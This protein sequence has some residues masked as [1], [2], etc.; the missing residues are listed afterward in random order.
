MKQI[1]KFLDKHYEN[2]LRLVK[3]FD[4]TKEK[5]WDSL[6]Y[7]NELYVQLGHVYN[8]LNPNNNV[9][10]DGRKIDNLGDELSDVVLQLINLADNLGINM[11]EVKNVENY[12]SNNINDIPILLGQLTETIMEMNSYRF[13]KERQGFNSHL[14]FAKDRIFKTFITTFN[15]A[16]QYNLNMIKE[17]DD[18]LIDATGFLEKFED[19]EE[20]RYVKRIPKD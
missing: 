19:N 8:V 13:K 16:K 3:A 12:S 14:D 15:I 17:F 11:Y 6:L 20:R 2:A 7:L 18:M 5:E 9:A 4:S 10:E 1:I